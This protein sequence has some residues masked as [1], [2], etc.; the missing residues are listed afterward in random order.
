MSKLINLSINTADKL[1]QQELNSQDPHITWEGLELFIKHIKDNPNPC[2]TRQEYIK[3][4]LSTNDL[5]S[6][7]ANYSAL[8]ILFNL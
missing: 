2:K 4:I 8:D 7:Q 6:Q 1:T 3:N 5:M